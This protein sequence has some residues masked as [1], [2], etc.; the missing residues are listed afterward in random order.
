MYATV[1]AA[2]L[3]TLKKGLG[4]GFDGVHEAAWSKVYGVRSRTMIEES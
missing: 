4:D 1:G 3:F 2:L